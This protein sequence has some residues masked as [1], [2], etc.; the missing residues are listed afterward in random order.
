MF[1]LMRKS[2]TS[3]FRFVGALAPLGPVSVSDVAKLFQRDETPAVERKG[4]V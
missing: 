1:G 3:W 2:P 4:E